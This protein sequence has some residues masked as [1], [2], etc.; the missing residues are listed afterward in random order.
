MRGMR[1]RRSENAMSCLKR[2]PCQLCWGFIDTC[3]WEMPF[4]TG[5]RI[6]GSGEG[7]H[8]G[9]DC[10][11]L[12]LEIL[13]SN[14]TSRRTILRIK[15]EEGYRSRYHISSAF[16]LPIHTPSMVPSSKETCWPPLHQ[17]FQFT[18]SVYFFWKQLKGNRE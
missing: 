7:S 1:K 9:S 17:R 8:P 10:L 5:L 11:T 12:S 16:D 2:S 3:S 14:Q 15:Y 4:K 18:G 13:L 6:L